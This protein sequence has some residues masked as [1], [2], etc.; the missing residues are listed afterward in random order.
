M[1]ILLSRPS[2]RRRQH[3]NTQLRQAEAEGAVP[4]SRQ[5]RG[6][7]CNNLAAD[8]VVAVAVGRGEHSQRGGPGGQAL[9]RDGEVHVLGGVVHGGL[10]VVG[11]GGVVDAGHP[12]GGPEGVRGVRRQR[13]GEHIV[14]EE[15]EYLVRRAQDG[16][17]RVGR[18]ADQVRRPLVAVD[19]VQERSI[20]YA[21]DTVGVPLAADGED[22]FGNATDPVGPRAVRL[23][24]LEATSY[25]HVC[26]KK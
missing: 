24:V 17:A 3:G 9:E 22:G 13:G 10:D 23:L 19:V 8:I 6:G 1:L 16:L 11:A 7:G 4:A 21:P 18:E 25:N 12:I 15:L 2:R 20:G 5:G 14:A 26:V